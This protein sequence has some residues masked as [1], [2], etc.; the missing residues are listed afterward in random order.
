MSSLV[1]ERLGLGIVIGSKIELR[2]NDTEEQL[3]KVIKATYEQVFGRERVYIGNTFASAEALLRNRKINVRGFV[4]ILAKSEFYKEKFFYNNSQIRLI[5]LNYK[6]LLGRAPYDQEEIAY[7]VDNYASSGFDRDIDSYIYSAEYD[8]AF[9]DNIVPYYRGFKSISGMKTVGFNRLLTLYQGQGNSDNAM[10]GA[11]KS[12]LGQKIALGL[13][14]PFV[15]NARLKASPSSSSSD[16]R[17]Y[18]IEVATSL[19]NSKVA[20]RLTRQT[21]QVPFERLSQS[22]QQIHKQGKRILSITPL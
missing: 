6:H 8:Q 13:P 10:S 7:H 22:Y 1:E 15:T 16:G 18:L 11:T 19:G 5:E 4:S 12:L 2:A 14:S 3:Q 17:V 9:G 20:V 21:L